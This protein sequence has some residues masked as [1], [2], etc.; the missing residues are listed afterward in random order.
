MLRCHHSPVTPAGRGGSFDVIYEFGSGSNLKRVGFIKVSASVERRVTDF[1]ATISVGGDPAFSDETFQQ[2]VLDGF[3]HG[4]DQLVLESGENRYQESDANVALH[5]DEQVTLASQWESEDSAEDGET[6]VGTARQ[7]LDFTDSN[8]T[9]D[10]VCV[11]VDRSASASVRWIIRALTSGVWADA[12]PAAEFGG[13]VKHMFATDKYLFCAMGDVENYYRWDGTTL[14]TNWAQPGTNIKADAFAWYNDTLYRALANEVIPANNNDGSGWGTAIPFGHD[15]TD[16]TDIFASAGYLV[17]AKPEGMWIYDGNNKFL[18]SDADVV[19]DPGNFQGGKFIGG[20][21]YVPKTNQLIKAFISSATNYTINDITPRMKGD[22]NK[23]DFGHGFTKRIFEGPGGRIYVTLDDGE[24]DQ[25]EVLLYNGIWFHQVYR[26][27]ATM[28]SSGYSGLNGWL[29]IND[30]TTRRKQLRSLSDAEFPNY[31]ASGVFSTPGMDGGLPS[32]DKAWRDVMLET[33]DCDADNTVK[34]EYRVDK[35]SWVTVGTV[36]SSTPARQTWPLA[37]LNTQVSGKELELRFTLTRKTGDVT[38]TP[39]IELPIIIR[40]LPRNESA[41]LFADEIYLDVNTPLRNN[42]GN[43]GDLYAIEHM[44]AFI[45]QIEDAK[46]TVIRTD[47][48]GRRRRVVNTDFSESKRL[49]DPLNAT[50]EQSTIALRY[51]ETFSGLNVDEFADV[52]IS[53]SV[54]ATIVADETSLAV[55]H[56]GSTGPPGAFMRWG[57]G[58]WK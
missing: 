6:L 34:I 35:G 16:V 38:V 25:A 57:L 28:Y 15:S 18:V 13:P 14:S 24:G 23:V 20:S 36:I 8:V 7:I 43:I 2:I 42:H 30:G 39:V 50:V 46:D 56:D 1:A 3:E 49:P 33:R 26:A 44:K 54:S 37:G 45:D 31:A 22:V 12:G 41:H 47:E 58:P 9:F 29:L 27:T 32:I 40:V 53:E 52:S 19:K 10:W 4:G 51:L 5:R 21:L 17:I 48:F 11:A 55:W